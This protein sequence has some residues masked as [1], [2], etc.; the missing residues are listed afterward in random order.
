MRAEAAE[1]LAGLGSDAAP[2]AVALVK[3]SADE[4]ELVRDWASEAIQHLGPPP[5]NAAGRLVPLLAHP[6]ANAGF[7]AATLIGR[8][9]EAARRRGEALLA[10]AEDESLTMA[11]RERCLLSLDEVGPRPAMKPRLQR[12]AEDSRR[13]LAKAAKIPL[14]SLGD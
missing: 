14:A 11:V 4:D 12:L 10:H 2:A 3:A 6:D 8:L 1:V 5:A 7:W 13:R 9:G